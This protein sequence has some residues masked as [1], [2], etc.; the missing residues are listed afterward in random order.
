MS[1]GQ[2]SSPTPGSSF[3]GKRTY[4]SP[5][6]PPK[7]FFFFPGR[8]QRGRIPSTVLSILFTL[9]SFFPL[10]KGLILF[11]VSYLKQRF[12]EP[13]PPNLKPRDPKSSVNL[14]SGPPDLK[15]SNTIILG[16]NP[17]NSLTRRGF[18][19]EVQG[20]CRRTSGMPL[21]Q[22]P[23]LSP[24]LDRRALGISHQQYKAPHSLT[25][26]TMGTPNRLPLPSPP[27]PNNN[28]SAPTATNPSTNATSSSKSIHPA[29]P[30]S[31]PLLTNNLRTKHRKKHHKPH[32]CQIEDCDQGFETSKDLRR[33]QESKHP[34]TQTGMQ[35]HYCPYPGY[36]FRRV[37][38]RRRRGRIISIGIFG[39]SIVGDGGRSGI[40]EGTQR[41]CSHDQCSLQYYDSRCA[42]EHIKMQSTVKQ[43]RE[44][45]TT[46]R[47]PRCL[48]NH[49]CCLKPSSI[50]I[51][52]S[53]NLRHY[54]ILLDTI[55]A[56]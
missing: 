29:F 51:A 43:T 47:I 45:S 2:S 52:R 23:H 8:S 39:R 54:A 33:H 6:F 3:L 13:V 56:Q 46:H 14:H 36:K 9:L 22:P 1:S 27:L 26:S 32:K 11:S 5:N 30:V 37:S 31:K 25:Q 35:K 21:Q 15:S 18:R 48:N 49:F 24:L 38:R 55:L 4:T 40:E 20:L 19:P 42:H 50:Q 53:V 16:R 34:D 41:V 44:R 12:T 7:L 10:L 17:F 28:S